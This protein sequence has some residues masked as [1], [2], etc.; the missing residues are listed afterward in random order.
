[1]PASSHSHRNKLQTPHHNGNFPHTKKA[2]VEQLT[3]NCCCPE[4]HA[5]C[6]VFRPVSTSLGDQYLPPQQQKISVQRFTARLSTSKL[7]KLETAQS[8]CML[9]SASC[10]HTGLNLQPFYYQTNA[11]LQCMLTKAKLTGLS[12]YN[13]F[14]TLFTGKITSTALAHQQLH[15]KAALATLCG[16][17]CCEDEAILSSHRH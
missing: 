9:I 11:L 17:H 6:L 8:V 10:D 7:S 12:A 4:T 5:Q 13:A 3:K 1:M 15:I 14:K 2:N 16:H